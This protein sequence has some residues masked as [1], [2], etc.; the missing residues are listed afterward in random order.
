MPGPVLGYTLALTAADLVTNP[1]TGLIDRHA[2]AQALAARA[3]GAD[4][5]AL[6]ANAQADVVGKGDRFIFCQVKQDS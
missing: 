3:Y 1:A 5:T 4:F 2:T 6:S